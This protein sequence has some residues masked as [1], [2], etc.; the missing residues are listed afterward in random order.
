[1]ETF[2]KKAQFTMADLQ[3][4]TENSVN[5][6]IP[7]EKIVVLLEHHKI[8][9]Q[10]PLHGEES[11]EITYFMPSVLKSATPDELLDIRNSPGVAPLMFRYKCG[12][13]PLGV[14]SSLIIELVS[15]HRKEWTLIEDKPYRNKI[16]FHVG[17]DYDTIT[18]ISHPTFMEVVL[19]RESDPKTSTS[20]VCA[21][22]RA[23]L[24]TALKGVHSDLKYHSTAS[25]QC[26]FECPSHPGKD[27]LCV[28]EK[29]TYETLLCL[30]NQRDI[31]RMKDRKHRVWFH[32]VYAGNYSVSTN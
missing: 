1:M 26:G 22:V 16:E 25:I 2:K 13:M 8:L 5:D 21:S 18:L 3:L 28:L 19:F 17:E 32:K 4:A 29:Q 23:T 12:Y 14:F 30:E 20:S 9:A 7:M 27:H 24:T 10:L 11:R 15:Q 6:L 31:I